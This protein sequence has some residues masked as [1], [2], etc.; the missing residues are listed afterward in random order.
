MFAGRVKKQPKAKLSTANRNDEEYMRSE[1]NEVADKEVYLRSLA[2]IIDPY[3]E[4]KKS[5][6]SRA[7]SA[8]K[9]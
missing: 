7:S 3:D 5:I 2:Q 9:L 4:V 6:G 8:N 1:Q